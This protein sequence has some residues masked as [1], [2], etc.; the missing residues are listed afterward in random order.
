MASR[1]VRKLNNI[2]SHPVESTEALL[3]DIIRLH[4]D[5]VFGKEFEIGTLNTP[6]EFAE[7]VPLMDYHS[8]RPY[9]ERVYENPE[10]KILSPDPVV[11][12]VQTSGSTGHPKVLPITKR[13]MSSWMAGSTATQM[14]FIDAHKDNAS[15]FDGSIIMFGAPA[16]LKKHHG[17]PLGYMTGIAPKLGANF[18]FRRMIKP[19]P[20]IFNET[21]LERKMRMY[22]RVAVEQDISVF[23]GITTLSLA[24]FR[25][26]QNEYGPWLL[27]EYRGTKYEQRVREALNDDGTLDISVLWPK[28]RQLVVT[29]IDTDPY[30]EWIRKTL[31]NTWMWE[32]YA[33]SEG[34]YGCQFWP[35]EG[36]VL[37]PHTNYLEF[38]PE[39]EI[40][41]EQP[42]VVPLAELRKNHRYEVVITN[43]MGYV[44][45]RIGDL[46]TVTTTDPYM[47]S[48]I[49]RKGR[50]VSLAGEKISDK[51][52][53]KAMGYACKVTGAEVQDYTVVGV[54]ED[55]IASYKVAAM[56][57]HDEVESVD[58]IRA[59]EH[60]LCEQNYEFEYVRT[61]GAL[62][63]T[64]LL[65][66]QS[67]YH[68]RTAKHIQAKPVTLTTDTS[69][70][71]I[72]TEV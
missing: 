28:L 24:F 26:M 3:D 31:P 71:G 46:V 63:P 34:Y 17:L 22:A 14:T 40:D 35:E 57:N 59:F 8:Y 32:A 48:S 13:G 49:G 23:A 16:E 69:V 56:F 29:G 9:L 43:T 60:S 50:V 20:D 65:K 33:G 10:G 55:G 66:M 64:T 6:E 68:Q 58:F 4:R 42:E 41:K 21:D 54:I 39:A 1:K 11:W 12:Y 72:C 25:R 15:I 53:S 2:I 51:H 70:F 30:R 45:Y 62:N 7:E 47:V 44:R 37:L 36:V 38:I 61:V 19:G 18:L 27:E 52:V 5:T 67:S